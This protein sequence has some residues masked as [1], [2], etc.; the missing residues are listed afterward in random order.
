MFKVNDCSWTSGVFVKHAF[1]VS[2]LEMQ[3]LK[4]LQDYYE[5]Q[6]LRTNQKRPS[7][8]SSWYTTIT[9]GCSTIILDAKRCHLIWFITFTV[10]NGKPTTNPRNNRS[11]ID[12][13]L[14]YFI[15]NRNQHLKF[16]G[17][18][19]IFIR[20]SIDIQS[21]YCLL[22]FYCVTSPQRFWSV[23]LGLSFG[24]RRIEVARN[25]CC[26]TTRLGDRVLPEMINTTATAPVVLMRIYIKH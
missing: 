10:L 19:L 8:C 24:M 25:N 22:A 17:K 15:F 13:T 18:T 23:I 16:F 1:E 5:K 20:H 7:T 21:Q 4:I 3:C 11:D 12:N 6:G 14:Q 2:Q 9:S 26:K